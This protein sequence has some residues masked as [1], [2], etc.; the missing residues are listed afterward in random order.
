MSEPGIVT[1]EAVVLAFETA[2][3]GS[4][5]VA[6]VIDLVVMLVAGVLIVGGAAL[7]GGTH[8]GLAGVYIGLFLVAFFFRWVRG[9]AVFWAGLVAEALVLAFHFT[10]LISYLWYN[11]IGCAACVLLS[12]LLEAALGSGRDQRLSPA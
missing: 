12:V 1:P 10:H 6:A 9:T 11:L 5:I 2:G 3:V 7:F 4:R 8:V